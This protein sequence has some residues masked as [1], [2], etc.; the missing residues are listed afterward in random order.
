MDWLIQDFVYGVRFLRK[1][2]WCLTSIAV[3]VLGLGISLTASMYAIIEGV[4]L[5]GPRLRSRRRDRVSSR[6]LSRRANSTNPFAFTTTWIG[7]SSNRSFEEMS[8]HF[9]FSA[10]LSGDDG[11]AQRYAGVRLTASTFDLLGVAAVVGA[12]VCARG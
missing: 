10:N 11:P 9:G 1:R 4:I 12:F 6:P 2:H 3:L 7:A 8:A 5:S